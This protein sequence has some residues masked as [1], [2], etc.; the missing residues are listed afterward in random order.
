MLEE[1][2]SLQRR[3]CRGQPDQ[4]REPGGHPERGWPAANFITQDSDAPNTH[5]LAYVGMDNYLAGRTCGK[6]VKEAMPEGGEVMIFVGR[7]GQLNADLRRQGVIDELLDRDDDSTR[8]DPP[9]RN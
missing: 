9:D 8:R 2:I 5:R 3:R 1:L 6:L 4:S 7:L